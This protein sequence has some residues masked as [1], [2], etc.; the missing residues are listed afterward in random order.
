MHL[1]DKLRSALCLKS[2]PVAILWSDEMPETALSHISGVRG[3]CMIPLVKKVAY[4]GKIVAFG[5]NNYGCGGGGHQLGFNAQMGP[6]FNYF[7][8]CG[9]PGKFE[10]EGYKKTPELVTE[11]QKQTPILPAPKDY[12]V[13]KPVDQLSADDQPE[14]VF[15]L[16]NP[17]QL[18]ALVVITNY[19]LPTNDGV[20]IFFGSGCASLLQH[21]RKER[22]GKKRGI[23][24]LTDVTVRQM[25]PAD[26]LSFAI[27]WERGLELEA[28]VPGSFFERR[29]WQVVRNRIS[30]T[31]EGSE[32]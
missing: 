26:I 19:D 4:E 8:S 29:A 28:N 7:L 27:P 15:F 18:S 13:F 32:K 6:E 22:L 1:F 16:V 9:I 2:Y 21:P 20:T 10:G 12:C 17:D 5:R 11:L 30:G 23:I 3:G 31:T 24:G 14:V 25:L